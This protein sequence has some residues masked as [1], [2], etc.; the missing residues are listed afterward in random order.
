VQIVVVFIESSNMRDSGA[1]GPT[2]HVRPEVSKPVLS[3]SKGVNMT[4]SSA[5]RRSCF[6]GSARTVWGALPALPGLATLALALLPSDRFADRLVS[7]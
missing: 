6:D 2:T 7:D 5:E 4:T 1:T 3:L